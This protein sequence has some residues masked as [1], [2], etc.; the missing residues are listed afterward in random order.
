MTWDVSRV[1]SYLNG[2][3]LEDSSLSLKN[4]TL[5]MVMLLALTRPSRLADLTRLNLT[6]LNNTP[7][8]AV[9]L[10]VALAKQCN[11]GREI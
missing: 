3:K 5:Q 10:P 2:H 9:F 4:L 11:P 1:L 8:G 6:E 7:E